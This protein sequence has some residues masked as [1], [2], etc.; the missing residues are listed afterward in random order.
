MADA[1]TRRSL[2]GL[3][4]ARPLLL[5]GFGA[6]AQ[7]APCVNVDALP[8]SQK[9]MRR[10]LAFKLQSP[11]PAKRCGTCT[12]FAATAAGCGKCQLFSGGAVGATSVC[13]GWAKK[14]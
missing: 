8:A 13:D 3:A 10:S 14:G 2:I 11:D 7:D 1:L 4:A 9:G 6:A 5:A 12:F